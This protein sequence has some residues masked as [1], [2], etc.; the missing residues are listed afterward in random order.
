V[1][2]LFDLDASNET[3]KVNSWLGPQ[4][5]KQDKKQADTANKQSELGLD[6]LR[7]YIGQNIN[8]VS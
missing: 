2:G 7:L 4:M 5:I 8:V 6:V 3:S 1:D